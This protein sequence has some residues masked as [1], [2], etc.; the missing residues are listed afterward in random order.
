MNRGAGLPLMSSSL[1]LCSHLHSR[2]QG[3]ALM[4]GG[5]TSS[6]GVASRPVAAI[7]FVPRGKVHEVSF[8]WSRKSQTARLH[9]NSPVSSTKVMVSLRPSLA[10]ITIG[11]SLETLL[12]KE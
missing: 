6:E 2:A 4:R 8:T 12:K 9:T 5:L 1:K 10:N 11:G 7:S 3:L